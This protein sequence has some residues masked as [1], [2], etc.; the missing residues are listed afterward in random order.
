MI[1]KQEEIKLN[2]FSIKV[3][4]DFATV[5]VSTLTNDPINNSQNMLLTAVGLAD[6]ADARYNEDETSLTD[7]GTGPIECEVIK[8]KISIKTNRKNLKVWSVDAEG[9]LTGTIP[10]TYEDGVFKF[11]IGNEFESIYYLIQ[12]Q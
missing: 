9:F 2:D 10:S 12:E 7:P 4:N 5:A 6:T 1:G 11:E 8:A 3:E